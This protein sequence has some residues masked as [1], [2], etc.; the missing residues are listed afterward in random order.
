MDMLTMINE[1][2]L[3]GELQMLTGSFSDTSNDRAQDAKTIKGAAP[4]K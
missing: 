2:V 3:S 4:K 1:G